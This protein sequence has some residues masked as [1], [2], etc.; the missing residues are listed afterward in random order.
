MLAMKSLSFGVG[1]KAKVPLFQL[2]GKGDW[3]VPP[4]LR[5]NRLLRAKS[6]STRQIHF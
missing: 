4:G 2:K 5:C 1:I 3:F 6:L